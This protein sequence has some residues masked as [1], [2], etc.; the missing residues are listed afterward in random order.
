[1]VTRQRAI[2]IINLASDS[3]LTIFISDM[4][5]RE[6]Y[7][8]D[9]L[10]SEDIV[11]I[12]VGHF[13]NSPRIA[14]I[15]QFIGT[16]EMQG[17]A[18][19]YIVE[20]VI[21]HFSQYRQFIENIE[22]LNQQRTSLLESANR[23]RDGHPILEYLVNLAEANNTNGMIDGIIRQYFRD[24]VDIEVIKWLLGR[25]LGVS[26]GDNNLIRML[27]GNQVDGLITDIHNIVGEVNDPNAPLG[28]ANIVINGVNAHTDDSISEISIDEFIRIMSSGT[29]PVIETDLA[30][31]D[32]DDNANH[33]SYK[34]DTKESKHSGASSKYSSADSKYLS[35]SSAFSGADS[36]DFYRGHDR[37]D[38]DFGEL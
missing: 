10:D 30:L 12:L 4:V 16:T 2:D 29:G 34:A 19:D 36:K 3:N 11:A 28:I 27:S 14:E 8:V 38:K 31:V 20:T 1:M 18:I 9:D 23:F 32:F 37:G 35:I 5:N 26:T 24:H 13:S 25:E 33:S 17:D 6:H 7:M 21:E 22:T 15:E